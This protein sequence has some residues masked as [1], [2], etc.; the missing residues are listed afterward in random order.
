MLEI[1]CMIFC[2]NGCYLFNVDGFKMDRYYCKDIGLDSL[3]CMLRIC[4]LDL[5]F[6]YKS[7][8]C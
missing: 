5:C 1:L 4:V 7:M 8:F 3:F 2:C 6:V